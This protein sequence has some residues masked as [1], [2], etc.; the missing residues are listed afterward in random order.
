MAEE[1]AYDHRNEVAGSGSGERS[2]ETEHRDTAR[3]EE[4][5]NELAPGGRREHP[6]R[7]PTTH[8]DTRIDPD[9]RFGETER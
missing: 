3:P 7:G 6:E 4:Q 2:A 1:G 5:T 9:P 8:D